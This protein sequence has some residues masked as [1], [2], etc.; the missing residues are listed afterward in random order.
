MSDLDKIDINALT[1]TSRIDAALARLQA[2]L[3]ARDARGGRMRY[4]SFMES[5]RIERPPRT[6][7]VEEYESDEYDVTVEAL[8]K[9]LGDWAKWRH[10]ECHESPCEHDR[11]LAQ[12]LLDHLE[13]M[14]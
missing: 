2:T 10:D 13:E 12:V 14:P 4:P 7:P 9:G 8:A 3:A 1:D 6:M 5:W 11:E